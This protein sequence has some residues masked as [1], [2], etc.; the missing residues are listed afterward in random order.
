MLASIIRF[1]LRFRGAVYALALMLAGFGLFTLTQARRDVY[2]EF[3]PPT[4]VVQTEAPGLSSEQVELLVTTPVES[5]LGGTQGV[6]AM[7]SK[8]LQGFSIVTLT[9]DEHVDVFR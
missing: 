2:P 6:Q 3:A 1:S 5:Q 8:S 4:A 9:F 7:R